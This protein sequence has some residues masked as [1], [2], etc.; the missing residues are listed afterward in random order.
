M[1]LFEANTGQIFKHKQRIFAVFFNE[2]LRNPM[3][4]IRH[5]TVLSP[6]NG[7]KSTFCRFCT[8]GLKLLTYFLE[9]MALSG[10]L[11]ARNKL[12][13]ALLI[14]ADSKE[15]QSTVNTDNVT[16]IFL[17][18][19]FDSFCNRNMEIPQPFEFNQFCCSKVV[20]TVKVFDKVLAFK[21]A[22]SSFA[23]CVD[24]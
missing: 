2:C 17:F 22:F 18:K 7:F 24:R 6:R 11:F 5:P 9:F 3:V 10:N 19:V 8:F 23:K 16:D 21:C 20:G 1:G 13:F 15:T 14:V 4:Y 12:R